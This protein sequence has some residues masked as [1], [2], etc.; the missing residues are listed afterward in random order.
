[1]KSKIQFSSVILLFVII[2]SSMLTEAQTHGYKFGNERILAA[3][4][5]KDQSNTSTCWCFSCL[6]FLE[7][8]LLR[9]G[10]GSYDLSEMY[11]VNKAYMKKADKF[12]RYQGNLTFAPGGA[13]N[14]PIDIIREYGIVPETAFS[15]LNL[16]YTKHI[17]NEMDG[18]IKSYVTEVVKNTNGV[19]SPVWKKGVQGILDAYLGGIPENFTTNGTPYTSNT[20][21]DA[22]GLNLNDY[23]FITSFSHHPFYEKFVLEVPDNWSFGSYY[24]VQVDELTQ[25]IDNSITNGYT[26]VWAADVTEPYFSSKQ[27]I[28]I[29]PEKDWEALTS[30]D[31][32][33]VYQ[34]AVKQRVITQE[35][36]QTAFDNYKTT[37]DH[38]M[39]ITGMCTDQNGTRFYYVKNS[40]SADSGPYKGYW[41]VSDAYVKY[42]TTSIMVHK[43]GIPAELLKKLNIN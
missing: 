16:G 23:V 26:V 20:Y 36:R 10:K 43:K 9:M 8:E 34:N 4:S 15:G 14:D 3:T 30:T 13:A 40:W 38:G 7:S 31:K 22:L 37:D 1:M 28:A 35:L 21:F 25:I 32:D 41:Y 17:H 19:L 27:G 2:F 33:S 42:K 5:V 24:N 11:V 39:H 18:T 6:S 29:V 12:V